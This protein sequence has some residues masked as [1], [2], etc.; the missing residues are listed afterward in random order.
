M[1]V[2][3]RNA[4]TAETA[5][6]TLSKLTSVEDLRDM[7]KAKMDVEPS[8]QRLFFQ[9]KQLEDKHTMFDYNLNLNDIIQLMVRQPL[10]EIQESN[11]SQTPEEKDETNSPDEIPVEKEEITV[12]DTE[13]ELYKVGDLVDIL[14]TEDGDSA[15]AWFEG[16]V[17]RVTKEEGKGAVAG[18]DGLTYCVGYE[19]YDGDDYK[20]KIDHL[21]PR[22]RKFYKSRELE[23]GME[24]LVNYNISQP[25]RRGMWFTAMVDAV[26]PL[27]CTV[28]AG[29]ELTPV[30]DCTILFQEEV[31][32]VEKA[33]KVE[34]RTEKEEKEMN[35]AVE[36]KHPEKCEV[37]HDSDKKKCKECG[38]RK[39]GK[40]D[41]QD[42]Q[43]MCDECDG[44]YHIKCL[45]LK[46]L[47]EEDE[48]FCPECKNEDNIVK[49][50]D[51]MKVGKKK[52]KMPSAT[53]DTKRDWG[54]GF[55]TVGRTKVCKVVEKD[56][57]GPIPGIEVGMNWLFRV[58][59][60]EEGI[61][62]PPVAGI[63]GTAKLGCPSLVLSGGYEDDVDNGEEFYYTGAGG[64]DLSGNKRTAEQSFDQE[65][66]RSNGA[67][68]LV[69]ACKFDD[70]NGGEAKDY[71]KG[72]PIRVVRGYKGAKHS[73][74]APEIGNRYDGIYKVVKYWPEKGK[75]GFRVWRYLIR[76]DD[77]TPAPWTKE[78]KKKIEEEG[79]GEVR[80]PEGY[81]EAQAEKEKEKAVKEAEKQRLREEG[82]A[83]GKENKGAGKEN[84]E[85]GKKRK[86]DDD[87]TVVE[88][89]VKKAKI[90]QE[91]KAPKSKFK[92]N[93][94]ILQAMQADELNCKVWEEVKAKEY[95]TK[96][97]L[98]EFVESQFCCIICQDIVFQPVTTPC[99]HNVCK[100]CLDRS[101]KAEVYSCSSCRGDLGK[102]YT[103]PINT[104]LKGALNKIFPGYEAGR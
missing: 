17:A 100:P 56:H 60:S 54:Q 53:G 74:F 10:S 67:L 71:T 29:V 5:L 12:T 43:I 91:E 101:F 58:Q 93:A 57:F 94:E 90:F 82:K 21:R 78:G 32:R 4:L 44:A 55:A 50:G 33:V 31:M 62:R 27:V 3:V 73:K 46:A 1:Y 86:M 23:V 25:D 99:L 24:V 13:S 83:A 92:P 28:M 40:K 26:R 52:A 18:Q 77:P 51:K 22:A 14:D 63:A 9:G 59:I 80:Y 47:P 11:L 102:D 84:K 38:C 64:R 2:K 70:E 88:P 7:I 76:R 98:T 104:H 87:T 41:E 35:T 6:I 68:A 89:Q 8:A 15:G 42:S 95:N 36:R 30:P 96:K 65:L 79:Y 61:H 49:I 97:D 20:V 45:G 85:K 72:K 16:T 48:W 81:H 69:C 19:A 39:C 66:T 75:S 37:C 103:K 34:D